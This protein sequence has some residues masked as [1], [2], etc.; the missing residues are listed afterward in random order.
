M[1]AKAEACSA[2]RAKEAVP[3]ALWLW[4]DH[5][6]DAVA[7]PWP[8]VPGQERS[9]TAGHTYDQW[10]SH[11]PTAWHS[12]KGASKEGTW[13]ERGD[14]PFPMI[15]SI[16]TLA[17][18]SSL[19]KRC[20]AC[21]GSSHV[22]GSMYVLLVGILTAGKAEGRREKGSAAPTVQLCLAGYAHPGLLAGLTSQ[23]WVRKAKDLALR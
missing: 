19:A 4:Q 7:L 17:L 21:M 1:T 12:H 9:V 20:T 5:S 15:L 14:L 10:H 6:C 11:C 3:T 13:P 2:G 18:S 22:S 23:L 8:H 16:L